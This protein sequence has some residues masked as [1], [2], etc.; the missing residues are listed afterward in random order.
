MT[1]EQIALE[2]FRETLRARL[3]AKIEARQATRVTSHPPRY[4]AVFYE[5]VAW[6]DSLAEA[7]AIEDGEH[8]REEEK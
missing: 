7:E 4:D 8:R 1:D 5:G 3:D 6:L 2:G